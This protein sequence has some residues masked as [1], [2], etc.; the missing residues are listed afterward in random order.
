MLQKASHLWITK[1]AKNNLQGKMSYKKWIGIF[2]I[3]FALMLLHGRTSTQAAPYKTW[4]VYGLSQG[5]KAGNTRF[6]FADGKLYVS[7]D[8]GEEKAL[9]LAEGTAS[10]GGRIV[11]NGNW[12]YYTTIKKYNDRAYSQGIMHRIKA[13]GASKKKLMT[14]RIDSSEP[15]FELAGYYGGR[16]Y[17]IQADEAAEIS[18]P[19]YCF[20]LKNKKAKKVVKKDSGTVYQYGKYFFMNA[21]TGN[22]FPRPFTIYNAKTGKANVFTKCGDIYFYK[23]GRIYYS[24]L[25][26]KPDG[27]YQAAVKRIDLDGKNKKTLARM[28]NIRYAF[29]LTDRYVKYTDEVGKN[30]VKRF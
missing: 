25:K 15:V 24:E 13:D 27:L 30:H 3:L 6:R 9:I 18:C 19:F 4:N 2:S 16:L 20:D 23:K 8:G 29:E 28:S 11:T 22:T 17:Y 10:L 5:Q 14:I 7:R 21:A 26:R 12:I 1:D